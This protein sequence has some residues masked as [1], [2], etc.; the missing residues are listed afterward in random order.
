MSCRE[1][2]RV[3]P[4]TGGLVIPLFILHPLLPTK[5]FGWLCFIFAVLGIFSKC[6]QVALS[7]VWLSPHM[8]LKNSKGKALQMLVEPGR[9]L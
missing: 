3:T 1:S 4:P 6:S 7:T 9:H 8:A 2:S 5:G